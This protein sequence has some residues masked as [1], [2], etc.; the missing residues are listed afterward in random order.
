MIQKISLFD[1]F[2]GLKAKAAPTPTTSDVD[3][4]WFIPDPVSA[5]N[6]PRSGSNL[7]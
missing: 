2:N 5:L 4:E 6:F 7:Y 3:P 1:K